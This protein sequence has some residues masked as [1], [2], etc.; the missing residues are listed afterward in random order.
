[1]LISGYRIRDMIIHKRRH[2]NDYI[3]GLYLML[4]IMR[5]YLF[6]KNLTLLWNKM[7]FYIALVRFSAVFMKILCCSTQIK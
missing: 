7:A 5:S 4:D 3:F 2:F 6:N 1:M